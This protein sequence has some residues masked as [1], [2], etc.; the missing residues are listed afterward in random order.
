MT[1]IIIVV[2]LQIHCKSSWTSLIFGEAPLL[3]LPDF[4]GA[5]EQEKVD[6]DSLEHSKS[7][8]SRLLCAR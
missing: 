1:L 4:R 5:D 2:G 6:L 8:L 3:A 7:R